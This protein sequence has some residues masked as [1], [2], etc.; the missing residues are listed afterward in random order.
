M[1]ERGDDEWRGSD[2]LLDSRHPITTSSQE[3]KVK[4]RVGHDLIDFL[5][6]KGTTLW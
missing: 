5:I 2:Y 6:D 3:P 4:L 1:A